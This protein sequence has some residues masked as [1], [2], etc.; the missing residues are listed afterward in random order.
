MVS[1]DLAEAHRADLR[2]LSRL[3]ESD[4]AALWRQITNGAVARELL[5][6]VLPELVA[7]YGSA[8]AALGADFYDELREIDEVPG[9]FR[10]I[11]AELPDRSRTDALARWGISPLFGAEPDFASALTLVGGGLQRIVADAD[12]VT[13]ARSSIADPAAEGWQRTGSGSCAF[14]RM[15]ISRGA[16]Y[17]EAGSDFASHDHCNCAAVPAFGGRERAVKP[18][19]PST[20][21]TTE[22]DRKRARDWLRANT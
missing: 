13:I 9:S 15:L 4:L 20:R 8:A 19:S 11:P 2:E 17:S 10:A 16:V 12:R 18:F 6:D 7:V 14:C 3:A 21:N 1:L 5:M 22:A